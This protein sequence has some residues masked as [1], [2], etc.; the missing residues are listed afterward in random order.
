[1]LLTERLALHLVLPHQLPGLVEGEHHRG[2]A[3]VALALLVGGHVDAAIRP[4]RDRL[5]L[6]GRVD[7]REHLH[8]EAFACERGRRQ[9]QG[10]QDEQCH[11][12]A[13]HGWAVSRP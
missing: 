10:R 8:V 2:R 4:D 12:S 3:G 6:P 5:R 7:L 11:V 1:V 13:P 9:C